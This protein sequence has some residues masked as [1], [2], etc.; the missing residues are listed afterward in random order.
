M[1]EKRHDWFLEHVFQH[2]AALHRYLGKLT[3]GAED[4]EDLVQETYVR[5][6]SLP[7]FREV[8]SP[9]AL[10]FR[11]AH[12]LAVERARRQKAQAT[13]TMG[14]LTTL[15]VYSSEAPPDEQTDTRRRFESFCAAVDRLPPL[16]RRVFVLRKV[17]KL[18]HAEISAVLGVSASTIEK[19]VAKG[20]VRCRD[21]LREL[22]LLDVTETKARSRALRSLGD[23]G[24]G[25]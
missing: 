16:C 5:L 6:Y 9:K 22:G 23:G 24:S 4:I 17:H 2:R 12:N 3:S 20:L 14:D 18:S 15:D 25:E 13:D 21:Y 1:A 8:E 19:H 7:D 11:I 10:L